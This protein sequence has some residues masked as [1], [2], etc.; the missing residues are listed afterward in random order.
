MENPNRF[1]RHSLLRQPVL[2]R[3]RAFSGFCV[4]AGSAVD[5]LALDGKLLGSWLPDPIA[6][7]C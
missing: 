6:S 4:L 2:V 7:T 3:F 5:V 1:D